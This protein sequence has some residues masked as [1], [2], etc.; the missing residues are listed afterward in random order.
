MS[1]NAPGATLLFSR[2]AWELRQFRP[3]FGDTSRGA[4]GAMPYGR[5]GRRWLRFE[6]L[7][8][9]LTPWQP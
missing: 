9:E 1:V 3:M 5:G 8:V 2:D 4:Y 6:R 7:P